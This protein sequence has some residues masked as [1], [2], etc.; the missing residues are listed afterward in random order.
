MVTA[1]EMQAVQVITGVAIAA[2]LLA[3]RLGERWAGRAEV[4]G[5][6]VLIGIGAKI[7]VDHLGG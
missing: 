2:W 4:L 5:G 3:G 7:L 1:E 6:L